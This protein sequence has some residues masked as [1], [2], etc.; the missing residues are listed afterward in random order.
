MLELLEN[1]NL[2]VLSIESIV[3]ILQKPNGALKKLT[4][5]K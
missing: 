5:I 1:I 4:V 2:Q 3:K